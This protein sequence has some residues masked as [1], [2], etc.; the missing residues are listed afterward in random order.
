MRE[1]SSKPENSHGACNVDEV[2]AHDP[3][4]TFISVPVMQLQLQ[5]HVHALDH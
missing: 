5:P 3:L 2:T 1:L 4:R